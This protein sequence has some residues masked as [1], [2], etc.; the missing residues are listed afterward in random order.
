M[1]NILKRK[2]HGFTITEVLMVLFVVGLL[3]A[4][5]S[6]PFGSIRRAAENDRFM[7]VAGLVEDSASTV[8]RKV[9]DLDGY[10]T[11]QDMID[12]LNRYLTGGAKLELAFEGDEIVYKT[13]YE[14][15]IITLKPNR[16]KDL[17]V[18]KAYR[19]DKDYKAGEAAISHTISYGEI[20]DN[21][22]EQEGI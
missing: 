19:T 6:S 10:L 13:T 5:S 3:F 20:K 2:K 8:L 4:A 11:D 17:F 7:S 14:D 15:I 18:L 1:K 16:T 22:A 21:L 9:R 12:D